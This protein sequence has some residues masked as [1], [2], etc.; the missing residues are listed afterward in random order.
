MPDML[1][2]GMAPDEKGPVSGG[3][4]LRISILFFFHFFFLSGPRPSR[5]RSRRR[6]ARGQRWKRA[7]CSNHDRVCVQCSC[8]LRAA[9]KERRTTRAGKEEFARRRA[10]ER[11]SSPG[12]GGK[13]ICA[14]GHGGGAGSIPGRPAE[15]SST[16]D[17]WPSADTSKICGSEAEAIGDCTCSREQ[18]PAER[19]A[20]LLAGL[21]YDYYDK[22]LPETS[23]VR[24]A[25]N[26]E[27]RAEWSIDRP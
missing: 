15:V 13:Y 17:A 22:D 2:T 3:L 9:R 5:E 23:G 25:E 6:Q 8:P 7:S 19:T 27:G 14:E 4:D 12:Q 1:H 11:P 20:V 18:V 24:P 26:A 16:V 21:K 10:S